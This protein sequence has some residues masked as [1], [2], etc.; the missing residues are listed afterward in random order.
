MRD[1]FFKLHELTGIDFVKRF[2]LCLLFWVV[3]ASNADASLPFI[4]K[5]Q[6]REYND[7]DGLSSKFVYAITKDTRGVL[8][9]GTE[10]GLNRF[11]GRAFRVYTSAEGLQSTRIHRLFWGDSRHLWLLYQEPSSDWNRIRTI[12]IFDIY[13][14]RAVSFDTYF[15]NKAPFKMRD[16]AR[17]LLLV[18]SMLFELKDGRRF[19]AFRN[20]GFTE[21]YQT[22]PK[23]RLLYAAHDQSCLWAVEQVNKDLVIYRKN[24]SGKVIQQF[25][26]P[27]LES[28]YLEWV[29]GSETYS[30]FFSYYDHERLKWIVFE[31]Q[32]GKGIVV[33]C[34]RTLRSHSG[35]F[36][37][38]TLLIK[39][40]NAI[41]L[42]SSDGT[43][44]V[45][46]N[47][48]STYFRISDI[49]DF[50]F[51]NLFEDGVIWQASQGGIKRIQ[52]GYGKFEQ[53]FA[54][55][56]KNNAFRSIARS[57]SA[58]FFNSES[59][60]F[61]LS[62]SGQINQ[63]SDDYCLAGAVDER[64]WFWSG[65]YKKLECFYQGNKHEKVIFENEADEFWSI[66][67]DGC[68]KIW[69]SRRGL[70]FLNT[71]GET[72]QEL[73]YGEFEEL[74]YHVIY[75]FYR[76]NANRILLCATSGIYEMDLEKGI[77]ARY[78]PGGKGRYYLP[79]GDFRHLYHNASQNEFWLATGGFGLLQWN[80]DKDIKKL[81]NF[82][83]HQTNILHCVYSDQNGFLWSSTDR[84]IVQFAPHS[85]QYRIFTEIDGIYQPE[86]NR[87]S[88]FQD[89]KGTLYFGSIDGVTRFNPERLG[90]EFSQ[91]F[92]LSPTIL[93]V[94]QFLSKTG[95]FEDITPAFYQSGQIIVRPG[96]RFLRFKLAINN[97]NWNNS[98]ARFFY[99][100]KDWDQSWIEADGNDITLAILPYGS[101]VLRLAVQISNGYFSEKVLEIPIYVARPFY[102]QVWFWVICVLLIIGSAYTVFNFRISQIR[103]LQRMRIQIASDLHDHVG[104][105]LARLAMQVEMIKHVAPERIPVIADDVAAS[106]R[107][108][109]D[110]MRDIIWSIDARNDSFENLLQ[111]MEEQL[112]GMLTPVGIGFTLDTKG[113]ISKA[114]L[115][116][117]IRQ[118][119]FFIFKEAIHNTMRHS[120]SDEVYVRVVFEKYLF[121]FEI[122]E[123][124]KDLSK[125]PPP[126]PQNH[127]SG[128]GLRNMVYRARQIGA[129]LQIN[130]DNGYYIVLTKKL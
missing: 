127:K 44:I 65:C 83:N 128:S 77:L 93:E 20:K 30:P 125:I 66:Y 18:E 12:D 53:L 122:C 76:L 43:E 124:Y 106:S 2:F 111:R 56:Q 61:C 129:D 40:F 9:I 107:G 15:N 32:A 81:Y 13:T 115:T 45:N 33:K 55:Q 87:I 1:D 90:S 21:I 42:V 117:T 119:A 73:D 36:F 101:R 123:I 78:W 86:F 104:A 120:K 62:D 8:W 116:G 46:L 37:S 85:G 108:S 100:V 31:Y 89:A 84:G 10:S 68:G 19:L 51:Q 105:I 41:F 102:L 29:Q 99:Q 71:Q 16:V 63:L 113:V 70:F 59:G 67:P 82:G 57:D 24:F 27:G 3:A 60:T 109:I 112:E 74:K 39:P 58:I 49:E 5:V 69:F 88:H 22:R 114:P 50:K 98:D 110:A 11:D 14:G 34:S 72:V 97:L 48:G 96:D 92:Q 23:E 80:P 25:V 17:T 4:Q 7:Q 6:I 38:N 75:H 91:V 95:R 103:K 64:G 126:P 28:K 26:L 130:S 35:L 79:V 94:G 52:L 118:H 47:D 121:Q 54:G